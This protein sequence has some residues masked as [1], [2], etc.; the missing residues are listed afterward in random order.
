MESLIRFKHYLEEA[1]T[2]LITTH[3]IPDADGVGSQIALGIALKQLGKTVYCVNEE[4]IP[5]KLKYLDTTNIVTSFKEF[6]KKVNVH[7]INL[8]IIVDANNPERVGPNLQKLAQKSQNFLYIDHHPSPREISSLHCIDQETSATGEIIGRLI[9]SLKIEF[10]AEMAIPLYTAIMVDSSSF[11][12]PKVNANTHRLVAQLM[13]TGA[14][15]PSLTYNMMYGTRSIN[16]MKFLGK[17]LSEAETNKEKTIAWIC[18]RESDLKKFNVDME[19]THGFIN[20]LLVLD[21]VEIACMFREEKEFVKVS[22]RS[23]STCDVG[24]MAHA[25]GGGGHNHAAA[26]QIKG[27]LDHVVKRTIFQLAI[28]KDSLKNK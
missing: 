4:E 15:R 18:I 25:L 7:E 12:Y 2:I 17:I 11:R 10:T 3:I 8:F 22:L 6:N 14:I 5:K 24:T 19:D 23:T 27:D 9:N 20:H 16:H 1:K 21:E 28:M 26:T 13:E